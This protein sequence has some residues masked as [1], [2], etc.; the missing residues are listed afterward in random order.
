MEDKK[1][2]PLKKQYLEYLEIEKNRSLK[3]LENYDRY[4]TRFLIFWR[5]KMIKN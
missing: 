2:L 3:T 5:K 1:L 4:L